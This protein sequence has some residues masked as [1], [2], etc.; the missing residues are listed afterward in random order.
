MTNI[1]RIIETVE[2]A[3]GIIESEVGKMAGNVGNDPVDIIPDKCVECGGVPVH[4]GAHFCKTC[5][6]EFYKTKGRD[7]Q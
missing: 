3:I 5:A 4:H 2:D 7:K 6:S 1:K